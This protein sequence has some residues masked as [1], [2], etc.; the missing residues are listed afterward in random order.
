MNGTRRFLFVFMGTTIMALFWI[1]VLKP[2]L[3]GR[4][5]NPDNF[6]PIGTTARVIDAGTWANGHWYAMAASN[7]SGSDLIKFVPDDF[8]PGTNANK[9]IRAGVLVVQRQNGWAILPQE[10]PH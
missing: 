2:A 5:P 6:R 1:L 3:A 7:W 9:S 4:H 10:P 8:V